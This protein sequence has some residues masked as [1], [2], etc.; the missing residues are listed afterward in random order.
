MLYRYAKATGQDVTG[1][2]D[3]SQFVDAGKVAGWAEAAVA[4]AVKEEIMEGS[5]GSY[6]LPRGSATRAPAAVIFCRYGQL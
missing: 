4:W 6:L 2:A 3:L 1:Q 5:P